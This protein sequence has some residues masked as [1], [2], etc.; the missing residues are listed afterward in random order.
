MGWAMIMLY[1]LKKNHPLLSSAQTVA[2]TERKLTFT[3][4]HHWLSAFSL[5]V[6]FQ[7]RPSLPFSSFSLRPNTILSSLGPRKEHAVSTSAT[8]YRIYT[9]RRHFCNQLVTFPVNCSAS[10]LP[11]SDCEGCL[12]VIAHDNQVASRS[13]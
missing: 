11:N 6:H 13:I 10:H 1:R 7:T 9:F 8:L 12:P 3:V 5:H 4:I 2:R